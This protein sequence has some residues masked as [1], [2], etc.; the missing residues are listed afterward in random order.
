MVEGSVPALRTEWQQSGHGDWPGTSGWQEDMMTNLLDSRIRSLIRSADS[1]PKE[2][3]QW[4][5]S[6]EESGRLERNYSQLNA[7]DVFMQQFFCRLQDS[8]SNLERL[9]SSA[10]LQVPDLLNRF[11]YIEERIRRAHHVWGYFRDKLEQRFVTHFAHAL[12]VADLISHDCYQDTRSNLA[13]LGT[14]RKLDLRDYP[15]TYFQEQCVSP[16]T[17]PRNLTLNRLDSRAL[18]VPIIGLPWTVSNSLWE[19]LSL[20][21]EVSHDI[22]E[23]LNGL[24]GQLGEMMQIRLIEEGIPEQRAQIWRRWTAEIFADFLAIQLAGPPFLGFLAGFLT[25]PQ[26]IVCSFV[27]SDPHPT[28]YVRL[29]LD[30]QLVR[31]T[32][33]GNS[34]EKYVD[35]IVLSWKS[36][37]GDRIQSI[38]PYLGDI[39]KVCEILISCPLTALEDKNGEVHT[40]AEL[41]K[42][43]E[44][45]FERQ[46]DACDSFLHRSGTALKMPVRHIVGAAYMAFQKQDSSDAFAEELLTQLCCAVE[47]NAPKGQLGLRTEESVTHLRKLADLCF[48][49]PLQ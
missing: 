35:D 2:I 17:W 15:L 45:D 5:R 41:I 39:E 13:R 4:L 27:Q 30:E 11:G 14:K 28:P 29:L 1:L 8:A 34:A 6:A 32:S 40:F 20:H 47:A 48:E 26:D 7:L 24:S 9:A 36:L 31:Q 42:C 23:D 19:L 21:H 10:P 37:Y 44:N 22:D 3:E 16:L 49:S 43:G 38:V 12:S 33:M 46:L 25:L 18:P